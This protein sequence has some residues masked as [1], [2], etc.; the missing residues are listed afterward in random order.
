MY[1]SVQVHT[2]SKNP[3]IEN[4]D[5]V[6]YVYVREPAL[7]GKAN[8]AVIKALAK[9]LKIKKNKIILIKGLKVKNKIFKIVD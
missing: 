8:Q 6:I 5:D 7:E 1:I 2:K 4:R 3:K 9:F